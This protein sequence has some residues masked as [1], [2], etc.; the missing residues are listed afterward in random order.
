MTKGLLSGDRNFG[1]NNEV[2]INKEH[3]TK[4]AVNVQYSSFACADKLNFKQDVKNSKC[5]GTWKVH[6]CVI[7]VLKEI[8]T[9]EGFYD[10]SI[11]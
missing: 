10:H 7:S 5:G 9:S 11:R 4:L 8:V 6:S 3:E 1:Q 2:L